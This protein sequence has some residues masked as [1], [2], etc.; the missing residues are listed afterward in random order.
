M[1]EEKGMQHSGN[2]EV[3]KQYEVELS[4]FI[5]HLEIDVQQEPQITLLYRNKHYHLKPNRT[6]SQKNVYEY[7]HSIN[8]STK[9]SG[10]YNDNSIL[11]AYIISLSSMVPIGVVCVDIAQVLEN[12]EDLKSLHNTIHEF[13]VSSL[14]K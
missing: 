6:D 4:S 12:C 13:S 8:I 10:E 1:N 2:E 3:E 7:N 9:I 5:L 14:S 11:K